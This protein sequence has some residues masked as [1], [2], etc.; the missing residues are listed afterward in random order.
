M[1]IKF[2]PDKTPNTLFKNPW[3]L[4]ACGFGIGKIPYAPGTFGS[5]LGI[6]FWWPLSNL[7]WPWY[8]LASII[9]LFIGVIATNITARDWQVKDPQAA[10]FDEVVGML[11]ALFL[12]PKVWWA[13]ALG[14]LLFRLFDIWKPWPVS[15][16]EKRIPGGWGI[17]LDDVFAGLMSCVVLQLLLFIT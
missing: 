14:F 17:V 15:W 13:V 2:K 1:T 10:C 4:I 12:V 5:L 3:H 6:L 9:I 16:A 8:L 11:F 7:A